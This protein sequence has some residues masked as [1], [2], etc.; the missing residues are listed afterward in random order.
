M[1]GTATPVSGSQRLAEW[2][3]AVK[4]SP[5]TSI[6]VAIGLLSLF[7]ALLAV[8]ALSL[9]AARRRTRTTPMPADVQG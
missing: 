1:V 4:Q 6:L 9:G 7:P 8:S 3:D 5:P 2:F